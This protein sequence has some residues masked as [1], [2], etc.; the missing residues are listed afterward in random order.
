M[1]AFMQNRWVLFAALLLLSLL[2]YRPALQGGFIHD[3]LPNLVDN[4]KV[5][6]SQ[7]DLQSLHTAAMSSDAGL[8]K[9]PVSML[10]FALNYYLFGDKPF[11]FKVVNLL[12]HV[13]TA[14]LVFLLAGRLGRLA[15]NDISAKTLYWFA[16]T[17][18]LL[19][20]VHPLHV[21]T[22]AYIVQRMTM[23]AALFSLLSIYL[24]MAGRMQIIENKG[25]GLAAFSL[26]LLCAIAGLFSKENA[27]LIVLF[28]LL[29]ETVIF[30]PVTQSSQYKKI[31]GALLLSVGA[32]AILSSFIFR[33]DIYQ[34]VSNWYYTG[35]EFTVSE[36][37]LT[38]ARI[39]LYYIKWLFFPN[40]REL[41][42]FHDDIPLSTSIS[43][44]ITTLLSLL[45]LGAL[46]VIAIRLRKIRPLTCLG[47]GWFFTGH[48]L[49]STVIP[50]EMVYE[51]R[52]YLPS[53][54]VA[55]VVADLGMVIMQKR[56]TLAPHMPKIVLAS[57][58]IF[59]L[60][61][62]TR[63]GQW[64]DPLSFAYFEAQHHPDSFRANHA[65]GLEYK[66]LA[67]AGESQ[68]KEKAYFYLERA[69]QL[70]TKRL[71]SEVGL[72]QL[73]NRLNEPAKPAW[74]DRMADKL[75]APALRIDDVMLLKSIVSCTAEHCLLPKDAAQI[76]LEAAGKNPR[77]SLDKTNQ[78]V[79]FWIKA[80][81]IM[82]RGGSS[83]EA[84]IFFKKA[85]TLSP[86]YI[87]AYVDYINL[88][89]LLNRP[90]E[91]LDYIALAG[92]NNVLSDNIEPLKQL[93]TMV[94]QA[95]EQSRAS[96]GR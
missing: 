33:G 21:S 71:I 47:I 44:P 55:L 88:L 73:S 29:I 28:V 78:S 80:N 30:F 91:A 27:V 39:V 31:L 6:L 79:Y 22:V 12:I 96:P 3:D 82:Q 70:G 40:I 50:L 59:S 26:A 86:G 61:T 18:A 25:S 89:L 66:Q 72:L 68:F 92:D 58:V 10:S 41:G 74:I 94:R 37:L 38:Q 34:L 93:E 20:L 53:A 69:S 67:E 36:R 54:G 15:L 8:L 1:P 43:S 63:A 81:F 52:N 45:A 65:L 7:L 87:Q 49:E 56:P 60:V 83:Q 57:A 42:L 48:L 35:R 77:L 95:I 51:H 14:W 13:V 19:W 9:R 16:C 90:E 75:A 11:S 4:P 2:I 17:V 64:A 84:E 24:Y 85:F 23:L 5:K 46:L 32:A 76:L 62:L